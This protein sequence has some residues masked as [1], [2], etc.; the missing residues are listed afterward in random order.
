MRGDAGKIAALTIALLVPACSVDVDEDRIF[1]PEMA[2]RVT[3]SIDAADGSSLI[4]R[5]RAR[6]GL[7][8]ALGVA[9]EPASVDV[10]GASLAVLHVRGESDGPLIVFCSGTSFDIA[11]HGEVAAWKLSRHGDALIWDYPG[12]G[13]SEGRPSASGIRRAAA[14]LAAQLDRFRRAPSQPIVFWGYSLGGFVCAEMAA[15]RTDAAAVILEATA[16]SA[17]DAAPYLAPWYL[18]PFTR[19]RLAGPIAGF[20]TV[21]VLERRP[22]LPVVVLSA[23]DDAV[24]PALLGRRLRD[25]LRNGRRDVVYHEFAGADHFDIGFQPDYNS[26]VAT[27]IG[28]AAGRR[29]FTSAAE[30]VAAGANQ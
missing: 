4:I 25:R 19:V 6:S 1:L 11:N 27:S 28:R 24:L 14:D 23:A 8:E 16:P 3:Y 21:A 29:T 26:V 9:L 12:Y 30:P 18:R 22:D 17:V 13:R 20:D 10:G 5:N 2:S 7:F 15:S